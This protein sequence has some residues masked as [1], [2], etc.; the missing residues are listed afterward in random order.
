MRDARRGL[1]EHGAGPARAAPCRASRRWGRARSRSA[2]A[3]S[4]RSAASTEWQEA[5]MARPGNARRTSATGRPSSGSWTPAAPCQH[6][7][8]GAAVHDQR[9]SRCPPAPPRTA[10]TSARE[11]AVG[12]VLLAHLH[13]VDA[14][15]GGLRGQGCQV[16]PRGEEPAIGDQGQGHGPSVTRSG[17]ARGGAD[18][19]RRGRARCSRARARSPCRARTRSAAARAPRGR[20]AAGSS[21]PTARSTGTT[22][23][24]TPTS[25][26]LSTERIA[27]TSAR[28]DRSDAPGSLSRGRPAARA[29]WPRRPGSSRPG[30]RGR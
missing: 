3:S 20:A 29:P 23:R 17:R 5:P 1:G 12:Q 18:G 4:A 30:R 15:R 2:P 28:G 21:C 26:E 11:R 25:S 13:A 9:A 19:P 8:V 16:A 6:G 22:T 24:T 10:A 14:G 7:E 27:A